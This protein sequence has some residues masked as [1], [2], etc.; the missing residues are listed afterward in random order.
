MARHVPKLVFG[1]TLFSSPEM[2]GSHEFP[3]LLGVVI[4]LLVLVPPVVLYLRDS[5]ASGP[6]NS[7]GDDDGGGGGTDP[8]APPADRPGG[9]IPLDDATPARVRLRG[10]GRLAERLPRRGRRPVH[11]PDR[12]PARETTPT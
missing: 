11:E 4:A 8:P 12:A 2:K 9:G 3:G 10:P 5:S 7:D 6:P 1:A